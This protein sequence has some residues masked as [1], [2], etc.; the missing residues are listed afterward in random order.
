MN[1][2]PQSSVGRLSRRGHAAVEMAL[3][4]PWIL[5]LF[6][7]VFDLGFYSYAAIATQNAARSAATFT[8][9]SW[10]KSGLDSDACE[11]AVEELR[12]LP[13]VSSGTTC[14]VQIAN[15]TDA[16]PVAVDAEGLNPAAGQTTADTARAA[17][18]TVI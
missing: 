4:S 1:H 16:Q 6:I 2:R 14:V 17:R 5:L 12:G 10:G 8:S 9:E 15:M 11:I 13:N 7:G 3:M 18:V